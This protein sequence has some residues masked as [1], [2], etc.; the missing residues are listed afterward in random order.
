MYSDHRYFILPISFPVRGRTSLL[1]LFTSSLNPTAAW[2]TN[3]KSTE[4][5]ACSV[6]K[7]QVLQKIPNPKLAL[8]PCSKCWAA[9][10]LMPGTWPNYRKFE[11]NQQSCEPRRSWADRVG[12]YDCYSQFRFGC[13]SLAAVC[14]G[15]W[16]IGITLEQQIQWVLVVLSLLGIF[17]DKINKKVW[18]W[19]FQGPKL[20]YKYH[21]L[22]CKSSITLTFGETTLWIPALLWNRQ[23][24]C[25]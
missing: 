19:G 2:K 13:I 23:I 18:G 24:F 9:E 14:L 25:F 4:I 10:S 5:C 21:F 22:K 6:I 11:H 7:H 12:V 3:L 16:H 1:L 15:V 8:S 17:W 20:F